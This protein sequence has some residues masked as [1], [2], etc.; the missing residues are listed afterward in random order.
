MENV[1]SHSAVL[2]P[3]V[4]TDENNSYVFL[5]ASRWLYKTCIVFSDLSSRQFKYA[6]TTAA[7]SFDGIV[8]PEILVKIVN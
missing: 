7:S 8:T 6:L 1:D 3:M 4:A 2:H 5:K